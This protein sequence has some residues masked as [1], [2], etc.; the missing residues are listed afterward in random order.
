MMPPLE[1]RHRTSENSVRNLA[2]K[3]GTHS[4][5]WAGGRGAPEAFVTGVRHREEELRR[6][7]FSARFVRVLDSLGYARF[8][9]WRLYGEEAL[10]GSA[11]SLPARASESLTLEHRGE[12]LARYEVE[13]EAATGRLREVGRPRLFEAPVARPQQ[14]LFA[15]DDL[16]EGGWL[17]AM[18]LEGYAP[19][20]PRGARPL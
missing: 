6:A 8:K 3:S 20:A 17:K 10:A 7:F 9:N 2:T 1:A 16:G 12:A 5:T 4:E 15:L 19:R 14:S 18:R 13:V 11:A